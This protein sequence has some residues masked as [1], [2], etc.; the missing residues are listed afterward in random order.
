MR[1]R[2][3]S[4]LPPKA[5]IAGRDWN[6]R[7]VPIGDICSHIQSGLNDAKQIEIEN[8]ASHASAL[9]KTLQKFDWMF[10]DDR[11]ARCGHIV[12]AA[13]HRVGW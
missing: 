3:M 7:F 11:N 12:A 10:Y 4:A 2:P 6:I 8:R 9:P 13:T 1:I 5:D